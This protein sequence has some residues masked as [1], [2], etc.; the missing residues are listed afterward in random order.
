MPNRIPDPLRRR[1]QASITLSMP[2]LVQLDELADAH[3]LARSA[4]LEIAA[5]RLLAAPVDLGPRVAQE[6]IQAA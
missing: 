4:I 5:L 1:V 2:V 6:A 3:G